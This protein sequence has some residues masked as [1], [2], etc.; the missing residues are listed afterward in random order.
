MTDLRTFHWRATALAGRRMLDERGTGTLAT[1]YP[2]DRI[3]GLAGEKIC[4]VN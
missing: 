4:R 2:A 3:D 1:V